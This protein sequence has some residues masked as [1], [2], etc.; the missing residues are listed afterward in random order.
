MMKEKIN[1]A[2]IGGA[3]TFGR[4][5]VIAVKK[6][7]CANLVAVC[8]D[9]EKI[10]KDE[11]LDGTDAYSDYRELLKRDDIDAVT[12]AVPDQIHGEI[13]IDCLKA[14]LNVL[15]E[16]PMALKSE[17]CAKMIDAWRKSGKKLMIGQTCR[18]APAFAEAKKIVENGAIGEI[19]FVES[20]YAHDYS[21]LTH[22]PWRFDKENPRHTVIGGGCHAVDLLRWIAGNPTQVFAYS[23]KKVLKDWPTDDCTIA[24][25]KFP[26]DVCGKVFVS[27]GCKRRYTMRTL[28]YGDKGTVIVDNKSDTFSLFKSV[29]E[30]KEEY[31][32]VESMVVE[33]KIPVQIND[34]NVIAE[35]RDFCEAIIN[36]TKIATDGYEGAATVAVCEAIVRSAET[37]MPE[38]VEYIKQPI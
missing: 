23:N 35:I 13:V 33:E 27:S 9:I 15:C 31:H 37:G 36:D 4:Q 29:K 11:L 14:G 7:D 30:G 19:F 16:K 18:Y 12:V 24:V 22:A 6:L 5:H 32:G 1:I 25:L 21:K 10:K 17:H 20:E 2:V 26:N 28:I 38:K 8:D 3:G 34:H